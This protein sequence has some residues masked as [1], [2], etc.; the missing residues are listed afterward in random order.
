MIPFPLLSTPAPSGD[1]PWDHLLKPGRYPGTGKTPDG[2]EIPV[3][4]VVTPENIEAIATALNRLAADPQWTG[5]LLDVE[6]ASLGND[7]STA[8][9]AWY[10]DFEVRPDGLWGRAERT[11]LGQQLISG[12][13]YKRLSPVADLQPIPN[14]KDEYHVIGLNSVGLTNKANMP[15]LRILAANRETLDFTPTQP[16]ESTMLTPDTLK[17]L[18]LPEDADAD[19]INA[20]ISSLAAK[21]ARADELEA[22]NSEREAEDFAEKEKDKFKGGKEAAKTLYAANKAAALAVVENAVVATPADA[23]P[24]TVRVLNRQDTRT[25]RS[26][27]TT[28]V[29]TPDDDKRAI[30]VRNRA[31]EIQKTSGIGFQAAWTRAESEIETTP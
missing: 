6:H 11:T 28:G 13:V 19:A 16:K 21:A 3:I 9:A 18:G 10:R 12:K 25:P 8:A 15:A 31:L 1:A 4:Q 29:A 22:A 27:V 17:L 24:T 14:R 30:R 20:A 23:S 26:P 7:G 5:L 2:K